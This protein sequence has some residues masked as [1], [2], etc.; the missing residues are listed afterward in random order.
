MKRIFKVIST[1]VFTL[2]CSWAQE[3]G[4]E[5][6]V[7]AA[8][9]PVADAN[10]DSGA[11]ASVLDEPVIPVPYPE[12][13]YEAVWSKDPFRFKTVVVANTVSTLAQDWALAGMYNY[14]GKHRVTI[15]NKQTGEFK[16]LSNQDK[17]D[18]EFRLIR[19][20]FNRNRTEA[21]ALIAKGADQA[22][23]TYDESLVS[24]PVTVNNTQV[25]AAGAQPGAPGQ[26]GAQPGQP[27][28][29]TGGVSPGRP[30]APGQIQPG[31]G[32]Q[33]RGPGVVSAPGTAVM[34][35]PPGMNRTSQIA[36]TPLP[37]NANPAVSAPQIGSRRR[38]LVPA[39]VVAPPK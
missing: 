2:G 24:K 19:A 34:A 32:Q 33:A 21:S 22:E 26:P 13:R 1:V 18:A 6:S 14:Q 25:A 15:Q 17:P 7:T 5:G 35:A 27:Q 39:P 11:G 31:T 10:A 16:H 28:G 36:N 37:I 29:R 12:S 3:S 9:V 30:G 20:N 23:L 8:P 4:E 38:Q